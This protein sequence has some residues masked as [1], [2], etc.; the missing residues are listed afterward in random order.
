MVLRVEHLTDVDETFEEL[1]LGVLDVL[2]KTL[3]GQPL[4]N[5]LLE[6]GSRV[7]QLGLEGLVL[8]SFFRGV[9]LHNLE[10]LS[11]RH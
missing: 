11:V 6:V 5:L 4:L 10:R 8:S 3:R 9:L 7:I 2:L 1:A